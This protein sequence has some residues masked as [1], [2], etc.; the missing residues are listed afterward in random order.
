MLEPQPQTSRRRAACWKQLA[1]PWVAIGLSGQHRSSKR[2]FGVLL[3][4]TELLA[5]G[6]AEPLRPIA[7]GPSEKRT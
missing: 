2:V 6:M 4:A 1:P 5:S 3:P 7:K